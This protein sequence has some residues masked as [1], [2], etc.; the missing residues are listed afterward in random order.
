MATNGLITAIHAS[1]FHYRN[2]SRIWI[3]EF[4]DHSLIS[5][6]VSWALISVQ[7]RYR[8]ISVL[9]YALG[10]AKNHAVRRFSSRSIQIIAIRISRSMKP[11]RAAFHADDGSLK[12][13]VYISVY[14]VF[15]LSLR[16]AHCSISSRPGRSHAG[17]CA[18]GRYPE[19]HGQLHLYRNRVAPLVVSRLGPIQFLDQLVRNPVSL[20]TVP[21]L[22][23][24][25][26]LETRTIPRWVL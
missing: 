20:V 22:V 12:S 26:H 11:S 9:Y 4:Y 13:S 16:L 18:S 7:C 5:I 15:D 6:F 2:C 24:Q 10:S 1:N 8:K 23:S 17:P 19:Y 21:A 25:L 14:R 3:G